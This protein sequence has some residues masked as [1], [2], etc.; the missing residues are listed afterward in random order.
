MFITRKIRKAKLLEKTKGKEVFL[1]V[2]YLG[3]EDKLPLRTCGEGLIPSPAFGRWCRRNANGYSYADKEQPKEYR[4]VT[5]VY[6]HP[7]NRIEIPER[8]VDLYRHC[9][10]R[11]YVEA[12]ELKI[13]LLAN[14]LGEMFFVSKI[15]KDTTDTE[16]ITAVNMF[17]E[18]FGQCYISEKLEIEAPERMEILEWEI[19]PPGTKPSEIVEQMNHGSKKAAALFSE[20]RVK[21]LENKPYICVGK[22]INGSF[23][24]LAF[25]FQKICIFESC[26]YGNATYVIGSLNW[27]ELSKKT[28][29]ELLDEKDVLEKV[30]HN[31]NWTNKMEE[32]FQKYEN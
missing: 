16:F 9:Y 28:K 11:K 8:P 32:L 31:E 18:I 13:F 15:L 20:E 2:S 1:Y 29:K 3:F 27:K 17:I 7:W 5:T 25:V 30:I 26:Y 23:G 21:Y 14:Q 10:P 24:Y 12:T 6:M 22:G 4:Y 19:L